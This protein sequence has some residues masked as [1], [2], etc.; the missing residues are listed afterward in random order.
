M[1]DSF[2]QTPELEKLKKIEEEQELP[3]PVQNDSLDSEVI[4]NA[5]ENHKYVLT[6]LSQP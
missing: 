3:T 5:L 2:Y 1:P 4:K 6:Q